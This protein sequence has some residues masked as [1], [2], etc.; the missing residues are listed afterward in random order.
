MALVSSSLLT[1]I[2]GSIGGTTYARS[3]GGLYA[4][5]RTVP[6]N[7]QTLAQGVVRSMFGSLS[8][9]YNALTSAQKAAW[10]AF[11]QSI[12]FIN[13]LGQPFNPSGRSAYMQLNQNLQLVGSTT[14]DDPPASTVAP[15]LDIAW[16]TFNFRTDAGVPGTLIATFEVEDVGPHSGDMTYQLKFSPPVI[17]ARGQSYRNLNRG[18]TQFVGDFAGGTD[19]LDAYKETFA[20]GGDVAAAP[21]SVINV[22]ARC[23]DPVT[24]LACAYIAT[25]NVVTQGV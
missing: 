5:N 10:E 19:L 20:G 24:G 7:P 3:R 14:I 6:I 9:A 25:S 13:R 2:S 15:V 16:L 21:G 4:R 1:D 17:A 12:Q 8:M 23:V 22:Q 11:G 18:N